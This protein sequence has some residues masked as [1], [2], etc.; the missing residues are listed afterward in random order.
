MESD[1]TNDCGP[2][3][4]NVVTPSEADHY[5]DPQIDI[6]ADSLQAPPEVVLTADEL[7]PILYQE[8]R[9]AAQRQRRFV[10]ANHTMQTTAVVSEAYLRLRHAARFNDRTHFLR[11]AALAMRHVLIN[12]ARD[13]AAAKRGSGVRCESLDNAYHIGIVDDEL[14]LDVNEALGRLKLLNVRLAQ[15]VECRFFAGYSEEQTAAALGINE[16][17]VRRDWEKAKAW[18][19][20]E[21]AREGPAFASATATDPPDPQAE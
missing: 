1:F 2:D 18:L 14:V 7:L 16:R 4:E 6:A 5:P 3:V 11:A 20:R 21:L 13:R 19:R 12:Y 8:L 15:V 10:G 9:R 17:T